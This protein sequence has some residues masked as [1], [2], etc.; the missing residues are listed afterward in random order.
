MRTDRRFMSICIR[1]IKKWRDAM[2]NI[3]KR[4]SKNKEPQI[5]INKEGASLKVLLCVKN[6]RK[7]RI[8]CVVENPTTIFI[9]DIVCDNDRDI[10]KGYGSQMMT[11][12]IA[13]AEKNGFKRIWGNLSNV[14][15]DHKERLYHFYE[16]FG[17]DIEE[18][19]EARNCDVG[20]V[21][22]LL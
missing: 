7:A 1:D 19:E 12:L 2:I 21:E 11:K 6:I 5:V 17:F 8:S 9:G 20:K 14:D 22:K 13:Y 10:N 4:K 3:F 15:M 18:Y 16:K